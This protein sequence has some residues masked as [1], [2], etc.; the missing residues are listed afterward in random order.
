[1]PFVLVDTS[2][3]LPATLSPGGFRRRFFVI[4][5]FG[6]ITYE[7]EHRRLELDELVKEGAADGG[8]VRGLDRAM[9]RVTLVEDRRAA[10]EEL[11]PY[12]TPDDWAAVGSAP[13]ST[14]GSLARSAG[15]S[16]RRSSRRTFRRCGDRWKHSVWRA[17]PRLTPAPVPP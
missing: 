14:S 11:L 15:S 8:T 1:M 17:H 16:T 13:T 9:Q 7:V 3:A 4:L 12:G 10:L 5:A 6:A 2:V